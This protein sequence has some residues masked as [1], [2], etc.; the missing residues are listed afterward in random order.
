MLTEHRCPVCRA[1]V[2]M[3]ENK[4]RFWYV[5]IA[6]HHKLT[7]DEAVQAEKDSFNRWAKKIMFANEVLQGWD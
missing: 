4:E 3:V 2:E 7:Y 5:C 6:C 1:L